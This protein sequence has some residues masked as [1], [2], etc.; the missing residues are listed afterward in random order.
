M[1]AVG[2]LLSPAH[3]TR[4]VTIISHS[5]QETAFVNVPG[6]G[7]ERGACVPT[8]NRMTS[9]TEDY[10]D[11]LWYLSLEDT[12]ASISVLGK[13]V[14]LRENTPALAYRA[15]PASKHGLDQN[16]SFLHGFPILS[17]QLQA[18][19]QGSLRSVGLS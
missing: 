9:I 11:S 16:P 13:M 17:S 10:G 4:A 7:E 14:F 2:S 1:S 6:L 19:H 8:L 3:L 15:L 18:L 12:V 5:L